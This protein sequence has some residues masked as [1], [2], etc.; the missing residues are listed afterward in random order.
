[1][2]QKLAKLG[3]I[4]S[5]FPLLWLLWQLTITVRNVVI[6][7]TYHRIHYPSKSVCNCCLELKECE[8]CEP[9]ATNWPLNLFILSS[10]MYS[11]SGHICYDH[12]IVTKPL[13]PTNRK[14]PRPSMAGSW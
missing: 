6:S 14:L 4:L 8:S 13:S 1:M 5:P 9:Y 2:G 11:E 10:G 3:D 12:A 7:P